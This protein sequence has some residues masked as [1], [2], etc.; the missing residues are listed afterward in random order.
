MTPSKRARA[1]QQTNDSAVLEALVEPRRREILRLIRTEELPAGEIARHFDVT[2]G[3]ISQHLGVLK[4]A[5]LVT[6]RRDGQRRLYRVRLQGFAEL[7]AYLDEF[8]D[9][10]LGALK[11]AAEQS[12]MPAVR[13]RKA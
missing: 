6:E 13:R 8:W 1:R 7:Q 12:A 4:A 5:G 10:R 9:T 3:A 11:Q 2:R